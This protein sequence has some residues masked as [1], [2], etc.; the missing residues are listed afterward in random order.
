M[1][2]SEDFRPNARGDL[3]TFSSDLLPEAVKKWR[4]IICTQAVDPAHT[5]EVF[6][7]LNI[8]L[9]RYQFSDLLVAEIVQI[10]RGWKINMDR[11]AISYAK[12]TF[13]KIFAR[14]QLHH[15]LRHGRD[16]HLTWVKSF[17]E[18]LSSRG[19]GF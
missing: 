12:A 17:T 6:T 13:S 1:I 5:P 14:V 2:T 3:T 16:V 18:T 9:L 11:G 8:I 10:V 15:V 4:A 7:V 19:L